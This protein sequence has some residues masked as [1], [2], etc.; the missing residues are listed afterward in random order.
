M[1]NR[2]VEVYLGHPLVDLNE[3]RF[4]RRLCHG[5]EQNGIE[6]VV[7]ANLF[8]GKTSLQLDF[9]IAR[10]D[11]VVH[12]ELKA[13]RHPVIGRPNGNWDFRLPD[14]TSR[15]TDGNPCRQVTEGT[16]ALSD[17]MHAFARTG[18]A[19]QPPEG[20]FYRGIESIVC[21]Y[22]A[23]PDG[24][25]IKPPRFV[26]V[27]GYDEL[28]ARLSAPGQ[29][30][31]WPLTS[32]RAFASH[33]GLVALD[34][35]SEPERRLHT[36]RA[37]IGDYAR[38]FEASARE[39]LAPRIETKARVDGELADSFDLAAALARGNCV[40]ITGR[41]GVG[42]SHLARHAA[43]EAA[44]AGCLPIWVAAGAYDGQFDPLLAT[45]F[46]A[47]TT[48]A[49]RE[50][51][52]VA[53]ELGCVIAI[54][55][56]GL[57]E[58]PRPLRRALLDE[59][60]ALQLATDAAVVV[61]CQERPDL[62][63]PL[64]GRAVELLAPDDEEKA[65]I[66]RAYG[67]EAAVPHSGPFAMPF[68]L[69][70]AAACASELERLTTRAE[71]LSAYV[72]RVTGGEQTRAALRHV[73]ARMYEELRGSLPLHEVLTMLQRDAGVAPALADAVL[74]CD[75]VEVRQER[76]AFVH[77]EFSRFLAAE[78]LVLG[79]AD[80]DELAARIAAPRY[81]DLRSD[82]LALEPD[83]GR[84][85][86]VLASIG[87]QE[88]VFA[89]A[90]GALGPERERVAEAILNDLLDAAVATMRGDDVGVVP[91]GFGVV[92]STR[93]EWTAAERVQLSVIGRLLHR[94][95]LVHRVASLLDATDEVGAR[96]MERLRTNGE[97]APITNVT[98]AA[99][100]F[101]TSDDRDCLPASVIVHAARRHRFDARLRGAPPMARASLLPG[102]P[103]DWRWGRLF[104]ALALIEPSDPADARLVEP[105]LVRAWGLGS[106]HLR[107]D[108]L[109]MAGRAAHHLQ[110]E[111]RRA[112]IAVLQELQPE[113]LG[114]S[115]ALVEALAAFEVITPERDLTDIEAEID[116][117]L[118]APPDDE[119]A[120][121]ARTIVVSQLEDERIV[122]P[123]S[124]AIACLDPG[125]HAAVLA[126]AAQATPVGDFFADWTVRQLIDDGDLGDSTTQGVLI[127][128]ASSPDPGDWSSPQMS[129]CAYLDAARACAQFAEI[130]PF[131]APP[132]GTVRALGH[133]AELAFWHAREELG[134]PPDERRVAAL[135]TEL[136]GPLRAS[137]AQAFHCAN[138]ADRL[139]QDERI[140]DA[141]ITDNRDVVREVFEWS[142]VHRS[143]LARIERLA[144][145]GDLGEYIVS[146]LEVVGNAETPALLR[147]YA[148]DRALGEAAA[149][150]VRAIEARHVRA[151]G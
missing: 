36:Q 33:L 47:H 37:R 127:R 90:T 125:R 6:A 63:E 103:K 17:D 119:A 50:V 136:A 66:L 131:D 16:Y 2:V 74:A 102:T 13:W 87:D 10:P 106:Y 56:D 92:W 94:G 138:M 39:D 23:I 70:I 132:S 14:G 45:A 26:K 114:V 86:H 104:L 49:P 118:A 52:S 64:V 96:E 88:V 83:L 129:M 134:A 110:G 25:K 81:A 15:S 58:C 68:E 46:A 30:G 1:K 116:E 9:V 28:V 7:F 147:G 24:S 117:L 144:V 53:A 115:S 108:A 18:E 149:A 34:E 143:E 62:P 109:E 57:N 121:R 97:R 84:V 135:W 140:H 145:N 93:R 3:K 11:R 105:L 128:F 20:K 148:D 122:G 21:M 19:P 111:A 85:S 150:A 78:A 67:A 130:P 126:L 29:R 73:A 55:V 151:A 12:C 31:P 5:F 32:W 146:V 82:V 76:I 51:L 95:R 124:E 61:T 43:I 99:Y 113:S 91:G 142:L 98:A 59:I 80:A 71:L 41:S 101:Q 69:S 112:V 107:L 60:A 89:A 65:Q 44:R 48:E 133:V 123:Y 8:A 54:V 120:Q 22:P 100:A 4:L 40:T 139:G 42:K 79:S 75:L 35:Q 38:R 137:V 141:L 72:R 77:E 27:M